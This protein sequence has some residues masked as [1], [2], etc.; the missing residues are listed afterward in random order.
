MTV[1]NL[2]DTLNVYAGEEV[3]V[4]VYKKGI[5]IFDNNYYNIFL[6]DDEV[7]NKKLDCFF[8]DSVCSGFYILKLFIDE[9]VS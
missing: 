2:L 9:C 7:L 3:Q 8:I 5:Q 4:E 1:K 6:L